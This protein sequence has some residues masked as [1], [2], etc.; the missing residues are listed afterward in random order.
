VNR[1]ALT[2][3][4]GEFEFSSVAAGRYSLAASKGGYVSTQLGA[5]RPGSAGRPLEIGAGDKIDRAHF[6][7]EP[8]AAIE[9]RVVDEFGEPMADASVMAYRYRTI[10]G[11]RQLLPAGRMSRSND[12]GQFRIFDLQ[13]GEY[14]LSARIETTTGP[15]E[16][17]T[18]GDD[19]A[20]TFYPGAT[21]PR[22]AASLRVDSGNTATADIQ[23]VAARLARVSGRVMD[24]TG[25]PAGGGF[26]M[27]KAMGDIPIASTTTARIDADGTFHIEGLVPDS[28]ELIVRTHRDPR[29]TLTSGTVAKGEMA[30]VP[31]AVAGENIENVVI[32]TTR[33]V[34]LAGRVVF[35]G[36]AGGRSLPMRIA[37]VPDSDRAMLG[38]SALVEPG[39]AF[40]LDGLIGVNRIQAT[41]PRGWMVKRVSCGGRDLTDAPVDVSELDRTDRLEVLL[42]DRVTSVSGTVVDADTVATDYQVLIFPQDPDRLRRASRALRSAEPDQQSV[43]KVEALP[44]GEYFAI[45][46]ADIDEEARS[47]PD[48]HERIRG[49][50]TP[51]VLRD[52]EQH[53][54]RLKL[55]RPQ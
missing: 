27:V 38:G 43:F 28:Y 9:G 35:E 55:V 42:T 26:I 29:A 31:L 40:V 32:T 4:N 41:P 54:L 34:R 2:D 19:Y 8:G 1:T 16:G 53:S 15:T 37:A 24:S 49:S 12:I 7:L 50:S 44:P 13:P 22:D 33:G 11:R 23:L 48:F 10:G 18:P 20:P 5:R 51:F 6:A 47:S 25:A 17:T 52:G 45:A 30:V 14:Y 39:G 21:N 36:D 46:L 3:A